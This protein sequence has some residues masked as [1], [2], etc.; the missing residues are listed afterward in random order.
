M[1]RVGRGD[2]GGQMARRAVC[3]CW[4]RHYDLGVVRRA[5]AQRRIG[6]EGGACSVTLCTAT[7]LILM[8]HS[9]AVRDRGYGEFEMLTVK[10]AEW[11]RNGKV[12]SCGQ[13]AVGFNARKI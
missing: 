3:M 4:S 12:V 13:S 7:L 2:R 1:L 9:I 6:K 11:S 5:G 8:V 10:Y